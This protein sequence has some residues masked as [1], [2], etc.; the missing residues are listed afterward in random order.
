MGCIYVLE[1]TPQASCWLRVGVPS[2][3]GDFCMYVTQ[4][5]TVLIKWLNRSIKRVKG[6]TSSAQSTSEHDSPNKIKQPATSSLLIDC[7]SA[8][9]QLTVS[10]SSWRP[11]LM[12]RPPICLLT[13]LVGDELVMLHRK[14]CK[15]TF[16]YVGRVLICRSRWRLVVCGYV[17]AWHVRT[18]AFSLSSICHSHHHHTHQSVSVSLLIRHC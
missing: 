2:F 13:Q 3:G 9:K 6:L 8:S 18:H 7:C 12:A 1:A 17:H 5:L 4:P 11:C 16:S 14:F 10:L 15:L